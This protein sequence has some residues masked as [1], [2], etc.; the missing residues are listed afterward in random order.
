[1]SNKLNLKTLQN[2]LALLNF[3]KKNFVG[4][5]CIFFKKEN[6]GISR[7]QK[8][9]DH[10]TFSKSL[11][12]SRARKTTFGF[13][14]IEMMVAVS[15]FAIVVMISMTAILSVVDSNK[16]AQSLKSVMNNLNFALETMTRSIKTGENLVVINVNRVQ[17]IDQNENNVIYSLGDGGYANRIV[18]IV[19][20]NVEPITA[21]EVEISNLKF[22]DGTGTGQ[23]SV[24]MIVQG[25]VKMSER[26]SSDFSIQT[27]V[28]QRLPGN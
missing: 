15:I 18:R 22:I 6:T 27:T 2:F 16:K 8:L 14:L 21:P 5:H 11:D 19:G 10:L 12:G 23:P 28:T 26:V 24:V 17:I 3:I 9:L 20:G 13:T 1:M 7:W 25:T 4:C